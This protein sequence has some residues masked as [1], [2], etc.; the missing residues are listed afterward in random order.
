MTIKQIMPTDGKWYFC[1]SGAPQDKPSVTRIAVWALM[2]DGSIVGMIGNALVGG[3]RNVADGSAYLVTAPPLPGVYK[4]E[5]DLTPEE[6]KA[7][8]RSLEE[9]SS[10]PS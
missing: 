5:D 8:R 2:E 1:A 10:Q 4:C 7:T 3:Q 9:R 6:F